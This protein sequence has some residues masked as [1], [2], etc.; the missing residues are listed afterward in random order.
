MR[1]LIGYTFVLVLGIMLLMSSIS[2]TAV[3]ADVVPPDFVSDFNVSEAL[4]ALVSFASTPGVKSADLTIDWPNDQPSVKLTKN[5][6]ELEADFNLPTQH[7]KLF[8]GIGFS[9]INFENPFRAQTDDGGSVRVD[10]EI[11]VYAARLSG[12][13]TF[14]LIPQIQIT[15]YVSFILSEVENETGVRDNVD[16]GPIPPELEVLLTDWDFN[17]G[18]VA[19]TLELKYDQWFGRRRIEMFGRYTYSYTE[20]FNESDESVE[21]SDDVKVIDFNGRWTAPTGL[22]MFGIPLRWKLLGGYTRLINV[23]K[24]ALGF[25]YFFEYGGGLDLEVDV[26]PF[27]LFNLRNIGFNVVGIGGD[28]VTGFAFGISLTN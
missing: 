27:N 18:T 9:H 7:F 4:A 25:R 21:S 15:P 19:G 1:K 2:V 8:T 17:T 28:D 13:L 12:G 10:P 5:A 11:D 14:Q 16:I 22:R 20:S 6:L 23:D 24:E 26:R 3:H